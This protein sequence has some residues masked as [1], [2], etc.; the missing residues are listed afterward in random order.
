M[1]E[2]EERVTNE[3]IDLAIDE[4][5]GP[6]LR[7]FVAVDFIPD[8]REALVE[9]AQAVELG[10]KGVLEMITA[11]FGVNHDCTVS[12]VSFKRNNGN[13]LD[14]SH[15][16]V[17]VAVELGGTSSFHKI[18]NITDRL[19]TEKE[20]L[21]GRVVARVERIDQDGTGVT[22]NPNEESLVTLEDTT[23]RVVGLDMNVVGFRSNL[24]FLGKFQATCFPGGGVLVER[25]FFL[26]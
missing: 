21:I 9:V 25:T 10:Q 7:R 17:V 1:F 24:G 3:Q 19:Q 18:E 8:R 13:A 14:G 11:I 16:L 15:A 4:P 26:G 22:L 6:N 2:I 5:V 20:G 23:G 12:E